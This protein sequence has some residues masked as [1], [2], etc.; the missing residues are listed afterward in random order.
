[1][2]KQATLIVV[3]AASAGLACETQRANGKP[4]SA[5]PGASPANTKLTAKAPKTARAP[6]L[7]AATLYSGALPKKTRLGFH[8][9]ALKVGS[10][11]RTLKIY[12]PAKVAA[13][14]PLIIACHGTGGNAED[15]VWATAANEAADQHGAV[16]VSLQARKM[17]DGDWDNHSPGQVYFQTHPKTKLAQNQDLQLVAA[18]IH[19]AKRAYGVDPTRVY[20][21]GFSNGAF[22]AQLAALALPD[23]IAGFASAAGGLVRCSGTGSCTFRGTATTS[24]AALSKQSGFCSCSGAAKPIALPSA[25]ATYKTAAYLAHSVRDD[26][27]SSYYSCA[28]AA[29]LRKRGHP[30]KVALFAKADHGAPPHFM[31]DAFAFLDK[32]RL[33]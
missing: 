11:R 16:V 12:F 21:A 19:A 22:F 4:T 17:K 29:E 28:L 20:T 2:S 7:D 24:C 31:V 25:K 23:Q 5:G 13:R 10:Q 8:A 15:G 6:A 9:G 32:H 1:M 18:V 27:V 14:P 30:V 26:V 3:L 33:K